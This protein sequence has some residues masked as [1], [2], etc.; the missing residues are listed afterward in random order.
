MFFGFHLI[1]FSMIVFLVVVVLYNNLFGEID[2]RK[3]DDRF[4]SLIMFRVGEQVEILIK[5]L[6]LNDKVIDSGVLHEC[7][8]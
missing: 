1:L 2:D 6:D 7:K 4:F 5:F 3:N 8:C